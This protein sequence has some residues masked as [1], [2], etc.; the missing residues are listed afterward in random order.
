MR[1]R[2]SKTKMVEK[3][4]HY[5]QCNSQYATRSVTFDGRDDTRYPRERH[6]NKRESTG[7]MKRILSNRFN[8]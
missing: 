7:A 6:Y 4:V 8:T 5:W 1:L 2:D 3:E